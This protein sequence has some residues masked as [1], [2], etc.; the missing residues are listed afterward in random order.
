MKSEVVMLEDDF[1]F[2]FKQSRHLQRWHYLKRRKTQ[3]KIGKM[4]D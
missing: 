2:Q 1:T 4:E 3:N